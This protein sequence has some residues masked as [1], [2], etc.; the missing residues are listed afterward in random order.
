MVDFELLKK[1]RKEG[2][3]LSR[4]GGRLKITDTTGRMTGDL[5][6]EI[7]AGK[8]GLLKLLEGLQEKTDVLEPAP[9]A[10]SY[11]ATLQQRSIWVLSQSKEASRSYH[12][13][14]LMEIR[15]MEANAIG[16][17]VGRVIDRHEV[18]RMRFFQDA[19]GELRQRIVDEPFMLHHQDACGLD[20]AAFEELLREESLSDFE[21]GS[22]S[23]L[24]ARLLHRGEGRYFLVIT[25]HHIVCDGYSL[26]L[27]KEELSQT[28]AAFMNNSEPALKPLPFTYKDYAVWE[29]KQ[30]NS[31]AWMRQEA[32]WKKL[33]DG[34]LPSMEFGGRKRPALKTNAGER[35]SLNLPQQTVLLLD[36]YCGRR[37]VPMFTGL[38]AAL[39]ILLA[40]YTNQED[41]LLGTVSM[42]RRHEEMASIVGLFINLLPVRTQVSLSGSFE[43][44]LDEQQ[45]VL[46]GAFANQ[47]L[48]FG[49]L[50]EVLGKHR[51]MSRS[52][53]FDIQVIYNDHRNNS[54]L[55]GIPELVFYNHDPRKTS[56]MDLSFFFHAYAGDTVMEVEYNTDL[57]EGALIERLLHHYANLLRQV[58]LHPQQPLGT[59]S[60]LSAEEQKEL[61]EDFN[62]T[63]V[64][65]RTGVTLA[66]L[67][68]E[69][70]EQRG[71]LVALRFRDKNFTY[72]D[73][74]RISSELAGYL[75]GR[76]D[77]RTE[78]LVAVALN[79]SE[80]LVISLLAVLKTGAAYVPVSPSFPQARIDF[81]KQDTAC[82][83]CIDE[84]EIARFLLSKDAYMPLPATPRCDERN[85]TYVIYTSGSTG[86]PKGCL[87]EHRGIVNRLEW[88][89]RQYGFNSSD[90]VLQKTAF[91]FDVSVWELFLPLCWGC[92]LVLCEEEDVYSPS[93]LLK[94]IRDHGITCLHF[95]PAM[96]DS[97]IEAAVTPAVD[98]QDLQSLRRVITSGEALA[99]KTV[100][101]WYARLDVPLHNLYGPT[102]ASVDVS[103]FD[104]RPDAVQ[105]LIGRPVANTQLYVLDSSGA[106]SPLGVAGEIYIGGVQ[107]GRGYLRRDELTFERFIDDPFTAGGRLYKTGD[108]GRWLPGGQ[109]EYIGRMDNQV[110]IRGYRVEL[111]EVEQALLRVPGIGTVVVNVVRQSDT[112]SVLVAYYTA[113]ETIDAVMLKQALGLQLPSYMVPAFFVQLDA[114]PLN[115]SGKVDRKQ[116][117]APGDNAL[118]FEAPVGEMELVVAEAFSYSLN[119]PAVSAT[120]DFFDAGGDS[121]KAIRL[122]SRLEKL[123]G[124]SPELPDL[125]RHPSIRSL[126][127]FLQQKEGKNTGR[128]QAIDAELAA[129]SAA[130]C[131]ARPGV[132]A[133]YPMSDIQQGMVFSSI[134][135]PDTAVY[136]DQ[137]IYRLS[138][139]HLDLERFRKAWGLLAARHETLRTGFDLSA[140]QPLQLVYDTVE[141]RIGLEDIGHL[142]PEAQQEHVS[143]ILWNNRQ[144]PLDFLRAPLWQMHLFACGAGRL[145]YVLEF[146]HAILDGWSVASLNAE[147]SNLY[148]ALGTQPAFRPTEL[149]C[150]NRDAIASML[151]EKEDRDVLHFWK[152]HLSDH[153][154]LDLFGQESVLEK[155]EERYPEEFFARLQQRTREDGISLRG[156]FF[157]AYLYALRLL[158]YGDDLTVGLVTNSRPVRE[159]GDRLLGCFL[160]TIPF[161]FNVP[162][163]G[164]SWREYILSVDAELFRLKPYERVSLLDI[165]KTAQRTG[166]ENPFFDVL[167][168]YVDFHVYGQMEHGELGFAGDELAADFPAVE[169]YEVNNTFLVMN[170]HIT[171]GR[172][173]IDH[174]L[175]RKLQSGISLETLHAGFDRVL[176][177]YLN[178]P[179][180]EIRKGRLLP[181]AMLY[182][183]THIFNPK[184]IAFPDR[185]VLDLFAG[186]VKKNPAATAII[187]KGKTISYRELD[188]LSDQ[189]ACYLLQTIGSAPTALPLCLDRS[190]DMIVA[191]LGVLKAGHAYVP[192]DPQY[193]PARIAYM[194]EDT[195][196][197]LVITHLRH[198]GLMAADNTVQVL[199]M[200]DRNAWAKEPA[201]VMA[202]QAITPEHLAYIIYTSG[203]TGQPKGVMITHKSLGNYL[204]WV[205]DQYTHDGAGRFG[206][207][208]SLAFDLTVTSVFGSLVC[209]QSLEIFPQ[210][211]DYAEVLL[212]YFSNP[213]LDIIKLTPAHIELAASLRIGRTSVR[214]A[215]VGGEELQPHQVAALKRL[216]PD[217]EIVNEYGPTEATV[218]CTTASIF[219]VGEPVTIGRPITNMEV[220]VLDPG[221]QPVP[222]CVRGEICLGGIQLAR[223]YWNNETLTAKKFVAHPFNQGERIYRTGDMGYWDAQGQLHYTGRMDEQVKIRGYRVEMG[224][225]ETALQA[226]EG[227]TKA[228]VVATGNGAGVQ[229]VA[230]IT[231]DTELD[232]QALLSQ[233]RHTLPGYMIPARLQQLPE[234]PVT[235]NG[236]TDRA[237]LVALAAED[238][239]HTIEYEEPLNDVEAALCLAFSQVL[240]KPMPGRNRNFF[241]LGGD[242][243]KAILLINR[244]REAGYSLRVSDVMRY[245]LIADL[246]LKTEAALPTPVTKFAEPESYLPTPEELRQLEKYGQVQEAYGLSPLQEGIYFHWLSDPQTAAYV[247]QI[248]YRVQGRLQRAELARSYQHVVTRHAVLR[249]A[250]SHDLDG[251]NLQVVYDRQEGDFRW[252]EVI[253]NRDVFVH[254]HKGADRREGFDLARPSQM[255]L[256]VLVLGNDEYEFVWTYHHILMDGWC[257]SLLINEFYQGY[258]SLLQGDVPL[259][260]APPAYRNYIAWLARRNDAQSMNYWRDYL[261]GYESVASVPPASVRRDQ[262]YIICEEHLK[263]NEEGTQK[264]SVLCR[265]LGITENTFLQ[266]AWGYLLGRYNNTADIVFGTV[267]SGRPAELPGVD[268]TIG[269]FINTIP[270]RISWLEG[271]TVRDLLLKVQ[272]RAIDGMAHHYSRL[273][274]VQGESAL[275]NRLFDHVFAYLNYPVQAALAQGVEGEGLGQLR[276]LSAE[277]VNQPNYDFNIIASPSPAGIQV[278]FRYN[279]NVYT[280]MAMHRV[281]DHFAALL[282]TFC[283]PGQLLS[284][285]NYLGAGEESSLLAI[286]RGDEVRF[287]P[288]TILS[289]FDEQ[290]YWAPFALAV[291]S[292]P[293]QLTYRELDERTNQ[294][295]HYLRRLGADKGS[296]VAICLERSVEL[297]VAQLAIVKAGAAWLPI[298]PGYPEE[299]IAYL[300][301]D[302]G[303]SVVVS[304]SYYAELFT[305]PGLAKVYLDRDRA[306]VEREAVTSPAVVV[307]PQDLAYVIY[308]SG[309]TGQPKG[310]MIE[311]A[312]VVNLMAWHRERYDVT[313]FSRS[314]CMAGVSFDA[315][316]LEI[317]SALLSGSTLYMV[318]QETKLSPEALLSFY[319]TH[320][321]THAFVPPALV[322]AL[323]STEQPPLL[324]LRYMLVGGDR[325]PPLPVDHLCY[326]IV[327]QYGPTESTVM[328]T[329]HAVSGKSDR[330]PPIGKPLANTELYVFDNT[331]HMAPIGITGEIYIGGAQL[332]RGYW[333]NETL[334]SE[335][336]VTHSFLPDRRLYR[337]GDLGRWQEEGDLEYMGRTDEQVKI[338]GYRIELGEVESTLQK[339]EGITS[340][341]VVCH[342]TGTQKQLAAYYTSDAGI[343][344]LQLRE[345]LAAQLPDYM[346]PSYF[347]ELEVLPLSVNGKVD[348]KALP[349]PFANMPE[350]VYMAPQTA[351]EQAL[352]AAFSELLHCGQPGLADNFFDLGGDSIKAILLINRL[353]QKGYDVKVADVLKY[354]VIGDLAA[355]AK[356]LVQPLG[357]QAGVFEASLTPIQLWFF[358]AGH[359]HPQHFNQSVLLNS[360][361]R[362]D[363]VLLAKA[364]E[365]LVLHHDALRMV[366]RINT[367]DASMQLDGGLPAEAFE[368]EVFDLRAHPQADEVMRQSCNRVQSSFDLSTG[369]L[370]KAV[371][372]RLTAG[373]RLLL[374]AHHLVIDG[375]SWR[376]LLADLADAYTRLQTGEQPQLPPKTTSFLDWAER[377]KTYARSTSLQGERAY[378]QEVVASRP[379]S[380]SPDLEDGDNCV[381][382]HL[383]LGFELDRIYTEALLTGINRVYRTEINDVLLS[384]LGLAVARSWPGTGLLVQLEGHG[385]EELFPDLDISRTV[386]WF[387]SIYPLLL[388]AAGNNPFTYLVQV[389][390][391]LRKVPVKGIGYG[392]LRYLQAPGEA[393]PAPTLPFDITFNYLGDFGAGVQD[394]DGQATYIYSDAYHGEDLDPGTLL[395][396]P[397]AVTAVVVDG[398]LKVT[399]GYS[400]SQFHASTIEQ[401]KQAYAEELKKLID[402]L[403][404]ETATYLTPSDLSFKKLSITEALQLGSPN[405]IEDAY[406]LSPLQQGIYF[407]W[408]ANPA[409]TA[410]VNQTAYHVKGIVN[411]HRIKQA[412]QALVDRHAVL[413]TF[414][415]HAYAQTQ[416]QVVRKTAPAN[417]YFEDLRHKEGQAQ[418]LEQFR[419][420][421][422]ARGFDLSNG[423]QMRLS[424]FQVADDSYQFVWTHHH[425]LMDGWCAAILINEFNEIYQALADGRPVQPGR[426]HPYSHYINWLLQQDRVGSL[427]YWRSYLDGYETAAVLPFAAARPGATNQQQQHLDLGAEK[428]TLIRQ[429]C[430]EMGITESSFVQAAWGYLLGRYNNTRDVVFGAVV[431]GRPGELQGVESAIGLFINTVPVRVCYDKGATARNLLQQVQQQA[432]ESLPHH[433]NRLSEVQSVALPAAD[434]FNHILVF[435][436]YHVEAE[437][438]NRDWQLQSLDTVTEENYPFNMIVVPGPSLKFSFKYDSGH[439]SATAIMAL[440][441]HFKKVLSCFAENADVPLDSINYLTIAERRKLTDTFSCAQAD[442]PADTVVALIEAQ[443]ERLEGAP[444]LR[445][446]AQV[447][448]Y[449]QLMQASN[450]LAHYLRSQGVGI[451]SLVPV[452]MRR[453]PE[454]VIAL[455]GIL[456]AGAAYVPIDPA[457]PQERIAT[458]LKDLDAHIVL[459]EVACQPLMAG[460]MAETVFLDQPHLGIAAQPVTAPYGSPAPE[461]LAYV[462]YT[463]GSTGKPKG[464]MISH[465]NLAN[466]LQW[467]LHTYIAG[468]DDGNFGLHSSLS[469]DLTVTSLLGSLVR[470]RCLHIFEPQLE[471]ADILRSY[472]A[473]DSGMDIIKLT[474]AHIG[475]LPAL[476]LQKT[477]IRKAIVGGEQL[478]PAHVEILVRLNPDIEIFNEYGPTEATVGCSVARITRQNNPVHIGRPI[479]NA[480]IYLLDVTMQPVPIGMPGEL[481][482]G[483]AQ[484]AQGYWQREEL[485]KERFIDN[486]FAEGRLYRTGDLARWLDDGN[487][488]YIGRTDDQ[489]KIRGYRVELG[490]VEALLRQHPQVQQATVQLHINAGESE[491]VAYVLAA[492]T[493]AVTELRSFLATRLPQYMVPA[494]FVPLHEWP[495][496]VNGKLDKDRLP[497]PFAFIAVEAYVAPANDIERQLA[498]LWRQTLALDTDVS[499]TANFFE[500]GGHSIKA[501]IMLSR[502]FKS[503]QVT[504]AMPEFLHEPTI[505]SL[506]RKIQNA[507]WLDL[508][509]NDR[510]NEEYEKIEI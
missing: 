245:P 145:L 358:D 122:V 188:E 289:L 387:T 347:V 184:Q 402:G 505:R 241:E 45:Q 287:A 63:E 271:D 342:D 328:V 469:F 379:Q 185:T 413:R 56:Q 490:E 338:R 257:I 403:K 210:E 371:L 448:S 169:S 471:T 374:V 35:R 172:L 272:L 230:Y 378:W 41:V 345:L 383:S 218:G 121:I 442:Y 9:P 412:Y 71:P 294:L 19:H 57:Y 304:D 381:R 91:T 266:A 98:V 434:L 112:D 215:I 205:L 124:L 213:A 136:R 279:G 54:A 200:D 312:S 435:E 46:D 416:L 436:N 26:N 83:V 36:D 317:W 361:Q 443:A 492:D 389:K 12:I 47:D 444:A 251:R 94:L 501:I 509:P 441:D 305:V 126:A 498:D 199:Y 455:L 332:A 430:R 373:D 367:G 227:I 425:I 420:D 259:L 406:E 233:L 105:V 334:T 170:V 223:G 110:K 369:P 58:L 451:N 340:A 408:L 107:L 103:F 453:S 242:S 204:H 484:V 206:L 476:G 454:Q 297:V 1:L 243:I 13:P 503:F 321:I 82:K 115:A 465:A 178:L 11:P 131:A 462:M 15:D 385:R 495:L 250:F 260:P 284:S 362:M 275:K 202:P 309:S 467:V 479:A 306:L 209:G 61:L 93:R 102:E 286:S 488:E 162:A 155:Y 419:K 146:H 398:R 85:L 323:V 370:F 22:Q 214:L 239:L 377:L 59:I 219:S 163:T 300:L 335:K 390:E 118:F 106:P 331:G 400:S 221:L 157:A 49:R 439:Y 399:I 298:D 432:I 180:E 164:T 386:G 53:V 348:R 148:T 73:L 252:V 132:S 428:T 423:S 220:F 329:D 114:L 274:D 171:G 316:A 262:P 290:L 353:K 70:V 380:L 276:V 44:A 135:N 186:Q 426:S 39:N 418:W 207:Y 405:D 263:L 161:R 296:I 97:F 127:T 278:I 224:E 144:Q 75:A 190:P 477:G 301:E 247:E 191:I 493:L 319:V 187:F 62:R 238:T 452:C 291:V 450:R 273:T 508:Q 349:N 343:N 394:A 55:P 232:T 388:Q 52:P 235:R 283:H 299:R 50:V 461:H 393:L 65:Y 475:L 494:L 354:P 183:L 376:L 234:F 446:G 313:P 222:I 440:R 357:Q 449:R 128:K 396:T 151:A 226:I 366:Y 497:D 324:A 69:Q 51:D 86:Q 31:G 143:R 314:T 478:Y 382:D 33:L 295:A 507:G 437:T 134:R 119:I 395:D 311:H 99:L 212:S 140:A 281:R 409:T 90:V 64:A 100:Q 463:S 37:R 341:I 76:Y 244:L 360:S 356:P 16:Q 364:I 229:L 89:W 322:P 457:Y 468:P 466:Y 363:T 456:K 24:R 359:P 18:F 109:L 23:P 303:A 68:R 427:N 460:S 237:A 474:P 333:N 500:L 25:I 108:I 482:I 96:L 197:K 38:L 216:N 30:R 72:D 280:Q 320:G 352:C 159:D 141:I 337:T 193:P 17:C 208:T 397:L 269:L 166:E 282:E 510:P 48:P 139:A 506:A 499:V 198:A 256:S 138:C 125:Y 411:S 77:I 42:G 5:M 147:L 292:G 325:L 92:T 80:W 194:L 165:S 502:I 481:Y 8:D 20:E 365:A 67:F 168:N 189:L 268:N 417:F 153:K 431:S 473:E 267:V 375:V 74:D 486:P 368:P 195:G 79:R 111:G 104:V 211:M 152:E 137:F 470:G 142:P 181:A 258:R 483:G 113:S 384:A 117:P 480:S 261:A 327:N 29:E 116:L 255:R 231:G 438:G 285:I 288:A 253:G 270:V 154:R 34:D 156:L 87:L 404:Q 447:L 225:V 472:F 40:R 7:R 415:L 464:V 123:T 228:A 176:S 445:M 401:L 129:M 344:S 318:D 391:T 326:V 179:H 150:T 167:F 496:T 101:S 160:N 421:D 458:I 410:Y 175:T 201:T 422:R 203:S 95:V 350:R 84:D 346:I 248:S 307:Q 414:F 81:I 277:I 14:L 6:N 192:I 10:G 2:I 130:A 339:I 407:H 32:Y 315:C 177:R 489:V 236:K 182:Q 308:T 392:L 336:F 28:F 487:L 246:A 43:E 21:L 265:Q 3:I 330:Q 264:I 4:E 78:D 66:D 217:I 504:L 133:A 491:L 293:D 158:S 174:L 485:T 249:T 173:L 355:W 372:Y 88:M 120:A 27:L 429:I 149:A 196:A 351:A 433:Y 302:S 254:D 240:Q 424:V 310:V 459:T 60:Y